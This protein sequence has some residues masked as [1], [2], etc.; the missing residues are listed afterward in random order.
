LLLWLVKTDVFQIPQLHK[1]LIV[2]G[3]IMATSLK[4]LITFS[5]IALISCKTQTN[6]K[7][8]LI[9]KDRT[10]KNERKNTLFVFVGEKLEFAELPYEQGLMD[11]GYKAKYK[12]IQNNSKSLWQLFW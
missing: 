2:S 1:H 6:S 3:N 9:S 10:I 5:L 7:T 12:I 8:P 4:L 11:A